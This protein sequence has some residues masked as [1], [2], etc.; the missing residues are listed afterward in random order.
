M[1]L[2]ITEK[3]AGFITWVKHD[4]GADAVREKR[5]C[6]CC[7]AYVYRPRKNKGIWKDK[8][9]MKRIG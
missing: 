5:K 8:Q 7:A 3:N 1:S 9:E 4:E 2:I 6:G